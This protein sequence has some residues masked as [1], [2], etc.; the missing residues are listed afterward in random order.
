MGRRFGKQGRCQDCFG[1]WLA[2]RAVALLAFV[3]GS[4]LLSTHASAQDDGFGVAEESSEGEDIAPPSAPPADGF[5]D[6]SQVEPPEEDATASE[7]GDVPEAI[8]QEPLPEAENQ[9]GPAGGDDEPLPG[10][11]GGVIA[12]EDIVA[13]PPTRAKKLPRKKRPKPKKSSPLRLGLGILGA[14]EALEFKNP[15]AAKGLE[16]VGWQAR[17]TLDGHL[18]RLGRKHSLR[19]GWSL[20]GGYLTYTASRT[21]VTYPHATTGP[22]FAASFRDVGER[23]SLVR[24]GVTSLYRV[25]LLEFKRISSA[26]DGSDESSG[27]TSNTLQGFTLGPFVALGATMD[28]GKSALLLGGSYLWGMASIAGARADAS[29]VDA[30]GWA[31]G[32]QYIQLV[33]F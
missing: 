14:W 30:S 15:G 16:F 7:P 12:P 26:Q 24:V 4:G 19:W 28:R 11:P 27:K 25:G 1:G 18:S 2:F 13:P 32:V 31:A 9:G 3:S 5:G 20:G 21:T 10:M 8:P 33:S 17:L 23:D 22:E 6:P 29:K